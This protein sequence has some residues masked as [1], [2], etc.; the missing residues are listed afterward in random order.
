MFKAA[1]GQFEYKLRGLVHFYYLSFDGEDFPA[2]I[3][4]FTL[5]RIRP[6][7]ESTL[8]GKYGFRF[9]PKFVKNKS[10]VVDAYLEARFDPTAQLRF[11]KFKPSVGLECLQSASDIKFIERSYVSNNI[12]PNRDLG[13][14]LNGDLLNKKLNYAVGIFNGVADGGE[15]T[16]TQNINSA[17]EYAI[18]IFTTPFS[19]ADNALRGLGFGIAGTFGTSKVLQARPV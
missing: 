14:S 13:I 19:D 16:A 17:K 11:G 2:A 10:A 7:F 4:G 1:D 15:N 9:T 8:F 5:R 12:L 18:R 6:T 3:D